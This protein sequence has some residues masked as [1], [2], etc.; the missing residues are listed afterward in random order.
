MNLIQQGYK[1]PFSASPEVYEECNNWSAPI[2]GPYVIESVALLRYRGVVKKLCCKPHC[3][4]SRMVEGKLKKHFF[5]VWVSFICAPPPAPSLAAWSACS[6]PS[7]PTWAFI[8]ARVR[9]L[10]CRASVS[11]YSSAVRTDCDVIL[12]LFRALMAVCESNN[13]F[14][15]ILCPALEDWLKHIGMHGLW[16]RFPLGTLYMCLA[17]ELIQHVFFNS[18]D[19]S[20]IQRRLHVLFYCCLYILLFPPFVYVRVYHRNWQFMLVNLS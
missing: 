1:L 4:A 20:Q 8:Q 16:P 15:Y 5:G 19:R 2:K 18:Y 10:T 12:E 6:F 13:I 9:W 11:I 7:V 14:I 17:Y 3:V